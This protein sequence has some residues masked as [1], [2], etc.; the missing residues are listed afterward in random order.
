MMIVV[1]SVL[2]SVVIHGDWIVLFEQCCIESWNRS[3][4]QAVVQCQAHGWDGESA[5]T[6]SR[7]PGKRLG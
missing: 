5:S 1:E 7:P 4:H 6:L 2:V 3:T